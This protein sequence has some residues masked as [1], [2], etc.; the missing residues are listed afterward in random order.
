[1]IDR[2]GVAWATFHER[3]NSTGF[4]HIIIESNSAFDSYSQ[5][6]CG[7]FVDGYLTQYRIWQRFQ[8]YKDIQNISR[9]SDF[10]EIW[11]T[12]MDENMKFMRDQISAHP[13]DAYWHDI[14]LVIA[15]FD[16]LVRGYQFA[17]PQEQRLREVDLQIIQSIGDIYDLEPFWNASYELA[18]TYGTECS[19]LVRLA[20]DLS[21]VYFSHNSWSDFRKMTNVVKDYHFEAPER[22][23]KRVIVT[24][25]MGALP[26]S[27]D[28]W[29]TDRGLLFL[30][31]TNGNYNRSLYSRLT[32]NSLLTWVRGLHAAWT[33]DSGSRWASE[34]LAMNSGTY[35]NQ[36]VIVDAKAFTPGQSPSRDLVW[37]SLLC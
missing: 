34:F 8:L 15:Q 29:M 9:H 37:S 21:D 10:P 7:G 12:W 2:S 35:N 33:A 11:R 5:L 17:A 20:P 27:E 18:E 19:G 13:D 3:I 14:S 16:G 32:P 30:E 26:S 24:T 28:F 25:K 4:N 22:V 23:T 1:V 36:Y 31:T 6:L